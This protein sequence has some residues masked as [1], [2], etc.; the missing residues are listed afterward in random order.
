MLEGNIQSLFISIFSDRGGWALALPPFHSC[1]SL[2]ALG[3]PQESQTVSGPECPRL[4][5]PG[6]TYPR[7]TPIARSPE[8]ARAPPPDPALAQ[9]ARGPRAG[10]AGHPGAA[11]PLRGAGGNGRGAGGNLA[12]APPPPPRGL[13]TPRGSAQSQR[14]PP[15]RA[16]PSPA[17]HT[18]GPPAT[19][20]RPRRPRPPPPRLAT[21]RGQ[22]LPRPPVAPGE[23]GPPQ[24]AAGPGRAQS[25][26]HPPVRGW[27]AQPP[28]PALRGC[29][30]PHLRLLKKCFA[31][32]VRRARARGGAGAGIG[33][34]RPAP[35]PWGRR[36]GVGLATS[37]SWVRVPLR[38]IPGCPGGGGYSPTDT[39]CPCFQGSFRPTAETLITPCH[40]PPR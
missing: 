2:K 35:G 24:L 13:P 27:G 15:S 25:G 37:R 8:S 38:E 22:P 11:G 21:D 31:A 1:N 14:S 3:E 7:W 36:E 16:G 6:H 33:E 12:P 26:P 28:P 20:S 19:A 10:T 29:D 34:V 5:D 30:S 32:V 9:V 39:V 40:S 4:M 18:P 23:A 17:H